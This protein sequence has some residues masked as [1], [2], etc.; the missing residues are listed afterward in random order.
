MNRRFCF[1]LILAALVSC[2]ALADSYWVVGSFKQNAVA[3][4]EADRLSALVGTT[5][6]VAGYDVTG[7]RYYR[8]LISTADFDDGVSSQLTKISIEPWLVS[9]THG[10]RPQPGGTSLITVGVD[11]IADRMLMVNEAFD[12]FMP[13]DVA[14]S[15]YV[16]AASST[17]VEEALEL[18]RKLSDKFLS[19]R[20]ETALVD[21]QVVHRILIGPLLQ[22]QVASTRFRLE[23][24]G[25]EDTPTVTISNDLAFDYQDEFSLETY[26]DIEPEADPDL[27]RA[28]FP[29]R[30]SAPQVKKQ[31][32]PEN[33]SGYNLARLPK[34]KSEFKP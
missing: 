11:S 5:I 27:I 25:F 13:A 26:I 31:L 17:E 9:F 28:Q 10:K 29:I 1:G 18:E 12:L 24:M 4:R 14:N 8:L 2:Q 7:R 6:E 16:V 19:V 15:L 21:G 23:N 3:D 20:G 32:L 34:K 30:L 33:P 22:R